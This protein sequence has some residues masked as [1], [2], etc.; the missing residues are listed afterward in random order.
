VGLAWQASN[1]DRSIDPMH[2][3]FHAATRILLG[4]FAAALFVA[5][6][7]GQG[8]SQPSPGVPP[9]EKNHFIETPKGWVHPRTPWGD[10]DIQGMFNF[11]YVGTV[12][13][14]RCGG[15]G[16]GRAPAELVAAARQGGPAADG[17]RGRQG[18]AAA[19][20]GRQGAPAGGR[21][22]AGGQAAAG[23]RQGAGGAPPAGGR[24]GG[25][26]GRGGAPCDPSVA[27]RP[28]EEYKVAVARAEEARKAGDRHAQL[29]QTGDFGG[30]LQ[31]GVTDPTWPQR[32]T[33]LIMDPPDG[34][35]PALTPEGSR[36]MMLMRSSWEWYNGEVLTWDSPA[37]F[38]VWDRCITRGM[39]ASMG[40]YRY[41]NGMEITQAPGY[42][43]LNLEMVHEARVIPVDGRPGLSP[44]IKQW[45]GESRG[46]WEGQTLVIETTNFKAGASMTNI[47]VAGSPPGNR[48][49]TSE[50]MKIVERITRL[51]DE[52][53][54]YEITTEDPVILTRPFTAR[55]PLKIDPT[56]EWW[57][58]ACHEG[59]TA[60]P[61]YINASR[62]ERAAA[63]AAEGQ[64]QQPAAPAGGRGAGAG[65]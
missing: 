28:E 11:S 12:P 41:N 60:I 26:G 50:S 58:Y 53:I 48:I 36:R 9:S 7:S 35:L 38:D 63:A 56:Y 24:A 42:V 22:A 21:A 39:P 43:V 13:L 18:G 62:A 6:L 64:P 23:G 45:M 54:L 3:T 10:P 29:L 1:L 15:G 14:E 40:P 8:Q 65:Q 37:D 59:N 5:T 46:R 33:S 55:M 16:A 57:E 31:S 25:R 47:G 61:N 30:A 4:G 2:S 17:G 19:A 32:Q 20:G 44:A 49:P 51:N 27:F 34:R 52:H